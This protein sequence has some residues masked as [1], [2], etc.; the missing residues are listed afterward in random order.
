MTE[1]YF[2]VVVVVIQVQI[3]KPIPNEEREKCW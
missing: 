1:L 3:A 2:A